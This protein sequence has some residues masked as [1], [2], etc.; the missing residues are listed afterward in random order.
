VHKPT[1]NRKP[2]RARSP[3]RAK[4]EAQYN[5]ECRAFKEKHPNCKAALLGVCTGY[6]QDV[7]HKGGRIGDDLL[8]QS[9]W[10]PVCRSCHEWIENHLTEAKELGLSI[11]KVK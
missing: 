6:T 7:H 3:K 9:M 8:D 5:K 10:L 11:S 2:L 4:Q 1:L